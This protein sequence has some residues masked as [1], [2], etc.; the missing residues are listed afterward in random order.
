MKNTINYDFSRLNFKKIQSPFAGNIQYYL[1]GKENE[2]NVMY[3]KRSS[4]NTYEKFLETGSYTEVKNYIANKLYIFGNDNTSGW[5]VIENTPVTNHDRKLFVCIM[6]S[7][8]PTATSLHNVLDNMLQDTID[9]DNTKI[10]TEMNLDTILPPS[11]TCDVYENRRSIVVKFKAP[12]YVHS[13]FTGLSNTNISSFIPD[14]PNNYDS[15]FDVST[16]F[17]TILATQK[18]KLNPPI[19]T[20]DSV[21]EGFVEGAGT[22]DQETDASG[23]TYSWMECDAVPLDY[24]N[25]VPTYVVSNGSTTTNTSNT[26]ITMTTVMLW[27]LIVSIFCI[28]YIPF[29]FKQL[30][31]YTVRSN[32]TSENIEI[33][34]MAVFAI[35]GFIL[36]C[37]GIQKAITVS[38]FSYLIAGSSLL[39]FIIL[40]SVVIQMTKLTD[41]NYFTGFEPTSGSYLPKVLQKL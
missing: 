27:I 31:T 30:I 21:K 24:S 29:F 1:M 3:A 20:Y 18:G 17:E 19:M 4:Q 2:P 5:L 11:S 34:G 38:D 25:V 37:V 8:N 9:M 15:I 35:T 32:R 12:V 16:N 39:G 26:V 36:L 40:V 41:S 7:T 28:F 14:F 13:Y 6:L 33:G 22:I 10:L 23:N